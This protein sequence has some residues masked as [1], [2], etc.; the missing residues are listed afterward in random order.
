MKILNKFKYLALLL[1]LLV[2][3]AC[4]SPAGAPAPPTETPLPIVLKFVEP[5][6]LDVNVSAIS[7]TPNASISKS[8]PP[9]MLISPV[10]QL[11]PDQKKI[12]NEQFIAPSFQNIDI[13]EIPVGE[14]VTSF[15]ADI[16]FPETASDELPV[17]LSGAH[18]VDLNFAD[19][20]FDND[21]IN[22]GCSGHTA[23]LP[24]CV[25]FWLD[26][27]KYLAWVFDEYAYKEGDINAPNGVA[28]IGKG[29][30]KIMIPQDKWGMSANFSVNYAEAPDPFSLSSEFFTIINRTGERTFQCEGFLGGI[31]CS[32]ADE[33]NKIVYHLNAS[34]DEHP[35]GLL[36]NIALHNRTHYRTVTYGIDGFVNGS[37]DEGEY[38]VVDY[39]GRFITDA[40]SRTI[41]GKDYW[42]GSVAFEGFL[43][44][45]TIPYE[46]ETNSCGDIST[47]FAVELSFCDD[48]GISV[49][50]APYIRETTEADVAMPTNFPAS[51]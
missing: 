37:V 13:I 5:S 14:T 41:E 10:I 18:H 33:V 28:T 9:G 44:G 31:G 25:R 35:E 46:S 6:Q 12:V 27:E 39:L 3:G 7:S 40:N 38:Y 29:R 36:K 2:L 24:V 8:F 51:P 48:L 21:G 15:S 19:Y 32:F 30:F 43:D 26:G 23:A 22:E 17:K 11:G 49:G 34:D 45:T 42:S 4:A 47:G 20:D 50:E 1:S 16:N